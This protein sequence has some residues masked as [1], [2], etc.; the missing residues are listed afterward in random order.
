MSGEAER[1]PGPLE[2][3]RIV[4][5]GGGIAAA[6]CT[7]LL[8]ELGAEVVKVEPPAGDPVRHHGPFPGEREDPEASGLFHSLNFGKRGALLDVDA[9]AGLDR[10]RRLL[11]GADAFVTSLPPRWRR[12]REIDGPSLVARHP[13]LVSVSI[14]AHGES[15]PLAE[16]P[17]VALTS[18]ALA[19]A[20]WLLGHPDRPPLTLPFELS[21]YEAGAAGA[22]A[23]AA[24][25]FH[26]LR[27]GRGQAVDVAAADV[28]AAFVSNFSTII[29]DYGRPWRREGRRAAGSAGAYPYAIFP[30]SDGHVAIIGRSRRDWR[31]IVAAMGSP[32]WAEEERFTDPFEISMKRP[33]EADA[34]LSEWMRGHSKEELREIA[35][36]HGIALAPVRTVAEILTEPQYLE[37]R[38]FAEPLSVGDRELT[39]PLAPAVLSRSGRRRRLRPAPRLAAAGD[40]DT[41]WRSA[42]LGAANPP[43]AGAAEAETAPAGEG[44][45][46]PAALA[47]IRVLDLSWVFSGP[48]AAYTL[49]DLGAEVIKVEHGGRLD[50]SRMR[51][52]PIRDGRPVEGPPEEISPYF[53][54]NNRGKLSVSL[55]MKHPD[56][57]ELIRRLA[58]ESDVL[59]ENLRPGVLA[60]AGLSYEPLAE[61]NPRLVMISMSAVGQRGP[62]SMIRAYAPI[63]SAL[64]GL[65]S[66]V[67]YEDDPAVGMMS[68]GVGDPN[69]ATHALVYI[70]A[71][72][73]DRERTGK[74]QF[75]DM[76]QTEAMITTLAEPVAEMQVAGRD[77]ALRGMDHPRW[78]P[79]GHYP[80]RGEDQWIA[81]AAED[82]EQWRRLAAAL[83]GALASDRRFATAAGRRRHRTE[84]DDAISARSRRYERN[85]L[86]AALRRA[87]VPAAA[88]V[89]S[90]PELRSLPQFRERGLFTEAEHPISG[91]ET[92]TGVPWR[93]S[94]TPP[95]VRGPA[96][97]VGQHTH[98]VLTRVLG[99]SDEEVGAHESS[100]AAT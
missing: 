22:A 12:D 78:A 2:G 50:N 92:L 83:G 37:R 7:R 52:Q 38:F 64:S 47:G 76:S 71:A 23:A 74:G 99:L 98:E 95:R 3:T 11:A 73:C 18:A 43:A 79:H 65:E 6:Y 58:D 19:G 4:E 24:A 55:N 86:A 44:A 61:R 17:G 46:G 80:C 42:G 35:D 14:T 34:L 67:G 16:E 84:L 93:L 59:I 25:L 27:T 94:L 39:P 21:E 81:I 97:T 36:R 68:L 49:A 72:L 15:G 33:D 9:P 77:P 28:I 90:I 63:M 1:R 29:V 30:C 20:S 51:G 56:G 91:P 69:A 62:L 31:N 85:E 5:A 13:A 70:L 10:L 87:G 88:L 57:A 45:R 89:G 75:V 100:G 26:R 54:Q 60:R 66:L 82:D 48:M 32:A 41:D 53:H 96:P 8:G 40:G